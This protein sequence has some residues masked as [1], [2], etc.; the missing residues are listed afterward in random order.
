MSDRQSSDSV[1]GASHQDGD[2]EM[3]LLPLTETSPDEGDEGFLWHAT[4]T[5]TPKPRRRLVAALLVSF[6]CLSFIGVAVYLSLRRPW[7]ADP[8]RWNGE[9]FK[10]IITFGDSYTDERRWRYFH[11]HNLTSPPPGTPLEESYSTYSGGR[12]WPRYVV[13]YTGL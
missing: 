6:L 10:S 11:D 9:T 7:V 5:P 1:K 13:Q 12:T 4:S 8:R 2:G 3:A